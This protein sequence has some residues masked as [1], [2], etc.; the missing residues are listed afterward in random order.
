MGVDQRT[1]EG[2]K[3]RIPLFVSKLDSDHGSGYYSRRTLGLMPA[4]T[5]CSSIRVPFHKSLRSLEPEKMFHKRPTNCSQAPK[6]GHNSPN[7]TITIVPHLRSLFFLLI[8]EKCN[9]F[10]QKSVY[11]SKIKIVF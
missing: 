6:S 11:Y 9:F 5:I 8:S 4:G 3:P 2:S 10:L 1:G 7:P